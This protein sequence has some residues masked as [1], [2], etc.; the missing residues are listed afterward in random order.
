MKNF[1]KY[2]SVLFIYVKNW[3]FYFPN[4]L[5][6]NVF[7]FKKTLISTIRLFTVFLYSTINDFIYSYHTIIYEVL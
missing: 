1:E 6:G 5:I 4:R 2:L 7:L 3:R